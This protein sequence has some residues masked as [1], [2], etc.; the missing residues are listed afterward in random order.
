MPLR[1]TARRR[2][3][4]PGPPRVGRGASPARR[5]GKRDGRPGGT[6]RETRS[7]G[8]AA[9]GPEVR[10]GEVQARF[11]QGASEGPAARPPPPGTGHCPGLASSAAQ[12]ASRARPA[13]GPERDGG[14]GW[15]RGVGVVRREGERAGRGRSGRRRQQARLGGQRRAGPEVFGAAGITASAARAPVPACARLART[16]TPAPVADDQGDRRP[17]S[18]SGTWWARPSGPPGAEGCAGRCPTGRERRAVRGPGGAR[19]AWWG[20]C[21]ARGSG[22]AI[23]RGRDAAPASRPRVRAQPGD[24][25]GRRPLVQDSGAL[26]RHR[27]FQRAQGALERQGVVQHRRR[28]RGGG[29]AAAVAHAAGAGNLAVLR[30]GEGSGGWGRLR[31]RAGRRY[32]GRGRPVPGARAGSSSDDEERLCTVQLPG[33]PE[34]FREFARRRLRR[35]AAAA[36][37]PADSRA[38]GETSPGVSA[39]TGAPTVELLPPPLESPPAQ[40]SPSSPAASA[41]GANG[42]GTHL[43]APAP[44]M[45]HHPLA[46]QRALR[47]LKRTVPSQRARVLDERATADRIAR[48]GAHPEAWM[49]V[50]RPAPDRWLRLNLVH[51]TGP[52]M[53]VWRPLVRELHAVL[54]QSGI[55]RT[56]TLHPAGP[57]AGPTRSRTSTTAVRSPWSS[58]TAWARS[59]RPGEAGARWYGT[60][61]RWAARMPLAVIQPLPEHLWSSTALP[62]EPG[63]LTPPAAAAP[64]RTLTFTPYDPDAPPPPTAAVPLPVLEPGAPWLANWAALLADPGSGRFPGAAAWLPDLPRHPAEPAV[65]LAESDPRDLA[66]RFR[67]TASPEA[68]RLA[69]HLA[70]AVPSGAGDA[71]RP[72]RGG[73]GP[74]RSISRRSSSAAC[75]GP[76]R[77]LPGPTSS[78]RAYG[79]CCCAHCR[80]TARGRTREFLA[81]VGGL[82]DERAGFAAG[83]F[84]AATMG[85]ESSDAG[86]VFATVSTETVR[87]LGDGTTEQVERGHPPPFHDPLRERRPGRTPRGPYLPGVRGA[88]VPVPRH[89]RH[90]ARGAGPRQRLPRPRR[91]RYLPAPFPRRRPARAPRRLRSAGRP[92]ATAGARSVDGPTP[93]PEVAALQ[94]RTPS[95]LLVVVPPALY[96]EFA[97]SSAALGTQRFQPLH[98]SG[99]RP[100]PPL[101]WYC[102]LSPSQPRTDDRDLVHGPLITHDL[103][104]LG[105]PEPG[106]TAIVH[107]QPDGPPHP[108][109]PGPAARHTRGQGDHVLRGRPHHSPGLPPGVPAQFRQGC[110]PRRRGAVLACRGPR[111]VRARRGA[112]G[113]R[114]PG[115]TICSAR[116]A[117]SPDAIPCV[118]RAQP[119]GR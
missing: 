32:D 109:Q 77:G 45:L 97:A 47:P 61:R 8:S 22:A 111:R 16:P 17:S 104:G 36:E 7:R 118:G 28:G 60:V 88:R 35:A 72:T 84:R 15:W 92:T 75:C 19:P 99:P 26:R 13:P 44:P 105:I 103:H 114:G 1:I 76:S 34:Q 24:P 96:E 54:A 82:I 65:D 78:G 89:R 42:G 10:F 51:D 11:G 31:T 71:P 91:P 57:T 108:P 112:P 49:P 100:A 107:T 85:G 14:G 20:R 53:P 64:S 106:R 41:P 87:R 37:G 2:G 52:T 50:L 27:A 59:G 33:Q 68:F 80:V 21:R 69:G 46:L 12:L 73:P 5:H 9:P 110:L 115:S 94:E 29:G 23:G 98:D 116:P 86:S 117:G 4:G 95:Y 56:V 113:L 79:S 43:L 74:A 55:F 63:L 58:A 90:P 25:V 102:P 38:T 6:P 39:Y 67:A 70:L 62:A 40:T 93:P 66:L 18:R 101:A 83:E 3:W 81:R 48:L 30:G 119:S